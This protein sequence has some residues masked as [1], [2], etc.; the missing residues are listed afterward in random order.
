MNK[1]V[2]PFLWGV[3]APVFLLLAACGGE[4]TPTVEP[5]AA[6]TPNIAATVAAAIEA[7]SQARPT[8]T[9]TATPTPT[10]SPTPVPTSTA[11][12]TPTPTMTS[13]VTPTPAPQL[14]SVIPR[15]RSSVVQVISGDVQISGV[16]VEPWSLVL[17]ASRSLGDAPLV[18]IVSESG[19]SFEG[20]V[21]GRDDSQN[22]AL[23]R[24]IAGTLAG[25]RLGDSSTL[26][27]GDKVLAMG[28]P[29]SRPGQLAAI[30]IAVVDDRR[31]FTTGI[32]FLELNARLQ[33][34]TVG[35]PLVNRDAE[36]VAMAVEAEFV[37]SFGFVA[38]EENFA[39]TSE[40]IQASLD[41]LSGGV[42]NLEPRPVPT[43]SAAAPPPLPAIYRGSVTLQGTAPPEG[44]P[45]YARVINTQLG[46]LWSRTEVG[47]GGTYTLILGTVN[48]LY[49]NNVVEFYMEGAKAQIEGLVFSDAG[50][51]RLKEAESRTLDLAF[52]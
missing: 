39:L 10:P 29:I 18:T 32:R 13:T 35:G 3:L 2:K 14:E 11:T 51:L 42:I 6:P 21:V 45:L 47:S 48:R 20:W 22:L 8:P 49:L 9:P 27:S 7:T 15:V 38:L 36:L 24:I 37:R 43:P 5:T 40:F 26:D 46:D 23:F 31:D 34:G 17:T 44:T 28:Y 19:E 12:A 41:R 33:A 25:I 4:A 1:S 52:P 16:V 30:E 50:V